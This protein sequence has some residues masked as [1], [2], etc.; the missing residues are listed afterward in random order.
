MKRAIPSLYADYGR[1]IDQFRAI[2]YHIDCLKPVE[3]RLL[4]TLFQ[5]A[6]KLTKSARVIGEAIGKY[7]PHGD[8][9]AYGTLVGLVRRGLAEGQGNWGAT[10]FEDTDPAAYRYTE[11]S[12]N[13]LINELAFEF[14]KFVPWDDPENLSY[15][16]PRFLPCPIPIGLI[17][18]HYIQG[19]SFHTTKIPRYS[20]DALVTRLINVLMRQ[21]NPAIAPITIYPTFPNCDVYESN[22][23]DFERV[24]TTGVGSIT[25]IP[26]YLVELQ[27]IRILGKPALG[28]TTLKTNASDPKKPDQRKFDNIDMSQKEVIDVWVQPQI[29]NVDQPFV[30]MIHKFITHN[31]NFLCNVVYDDGVVK[32]T[33]I[34][35]LLL[36][37][38]EHWVGSYRAKLTADKS[39][40]IERIYE[41][42]VISIVR[43]ILEDHGSNI[44]SSE[45]VVKLYNSTP[46]Y[47]DKKIGG[48]ALREVV[49]KHK[50]KTLLEHS[51]NTTS[52]QNKLNFIDTQLNSMAATAHERL[53]SIFPSIK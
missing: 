35:T 36:S 1:Y 10:G 11:V 25:V 26:K 37:S 51:T 33:S 6:K 23:G 24:L 45:D 28:F 52:V 32:T 38:Y 16:Q 2:P 21:V 46:A 13:K 41:L 29:G 49:Q 8:Q 20:M 30:D 31:L 47:Q 22:V 7:H 53:K 43:R 15:N 40:L 50:I 44:K 27:Q 39:G 9:S 12:A 42:Q 3:R 19:I 4:F 18:D 14:I 5:V 34:D 48:D 17:G